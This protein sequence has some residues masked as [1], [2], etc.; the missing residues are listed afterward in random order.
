MLA[1]IFYLI[2]I[3][4]YYNNSVL[5]IPLPESPQVMKY[6][7]IFQ[8]Y[9]L[10]IRLK[11]NALYCMDALY[12]LYVIDL[13]SKKVERLVQP[14]DVNPCMRFPDDLDITN[15]GKYIYFSDASAIFTYNLMI[16]EGLQGKWYSAFGHH[17]SSIFAYSFTQILL[18]IVM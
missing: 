18:Y 1:E 12:G 4:Y 9:F 3:L 11:D 2:S 13:T 16:Y 5:Y 17:L 10:G 8:I 7:L 14:C 6:K 15:D